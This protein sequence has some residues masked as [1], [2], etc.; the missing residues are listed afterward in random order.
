MA[1]DEAAA[2]EHGTKSRG[3]AEGMDGSDDLNKEVKC[4][5]L[6]NTMLG[7]DDDAGTS[8]SSSNAGG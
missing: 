7:A 3:K 6:Y 1:L 5:V 2:G 8:P 4:G